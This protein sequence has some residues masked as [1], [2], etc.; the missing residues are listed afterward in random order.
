MS[1][2][3]PVERPELEA[4]L[5]HYQ[6]GTLQDFRGIEAGVENTNYFVTTSAG[7]FVL[8][9][10]ESVSADKLPFILGFVDHL[11]SSGLA[12]AQPIHLNDSALFG[13]LNNRPAVLMNRLSGAPLDTPTF[14]QCSTIGA[15]LARSH[16]LAG[17][18]PVDQYVHLH[19]WCTETAAP[20]LPLLDDA[21]KDLLQ[22]A[23][24][25]AGQ[26][27]WTNLPQGPI[28]GD[29][30]PDN[31]LFDGERLSGL[32]DFYHSCSAPFLY[33]LA[34]TLNAWCYDEVSGQYDQ[35]KADALL[36]RYQA[37]RSLSD[38]EQQ[39]L[40]AMQQVAALRFWLSRLRDKL[41]PKDGAL[42]TVKDPAGKRGLLNLLRNA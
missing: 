10:V 33:D 28:H 38:E 24:M 27:P 4:Y 17:E 22:H 19:Q 5:T 37:R 21:D 26:I 23:L 6:V 1:I 40:P 3:T 25:D 36:T 14:N 34:V 13:Q 29:L 20:I 11:A 41:F 32:I 39:W 8:T 42:V 9:L 7:E 35:T 16:Q 15:T 30:F 18:L 2:Y 31:A 12:C